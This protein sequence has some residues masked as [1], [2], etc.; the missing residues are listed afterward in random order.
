MTSTSNHEYIRLLVEAT[1]DQHYPHSTGQIADSR[2]LAHWAMRNILAAE[3]TSHDRLKELTSIG[4]SNDCGVDGWYIDEDQEY[5]TLYLFQAKF[6]GPDSNLEE[7][8]LTE[9]SNAATR[10]LDPERNKNTDASQLAS[11]L[12]AMALGGVAIVMHYVTTSR[13]GPATQA[14]AD[15]LSGQQSQQLTVGG[16]QVEVLTEFKLWTSDTLAALHLELLRLGEAQ[17]DRDTLSFFS[18]DPDQR[19]SEATAPTAE[20]TVNT[21]FS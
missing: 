18:F 8:E 17:A 13:I 11:D 4:G 7:T 3:E 14:F 15:Q 19:Y 2:A 6:G 10:L 5:P 12:G 21:C 20:G 9:L 16:R 1:R